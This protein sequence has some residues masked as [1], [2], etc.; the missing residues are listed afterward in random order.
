MILERPSVRGDRCVDGSVNSSTV[1]PV[2]S[3]CVDCE[4]AEDTT[5]WI[6][7]DC[8]GPVQ[9]SDFW[10]AMRSFTPQRVLPS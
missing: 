10:A 1:V 7:L 2:A 3:G 8:G 5:G 4:D 6:G 9:L